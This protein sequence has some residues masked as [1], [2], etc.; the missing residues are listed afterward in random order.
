MKTLETI[1]FYAQTQIKEREKRIC[2]IDTRVFDNEHNSDFLKLF[3][4]HIFSF[5]GYL[6][7]GIPETRRVHYIY[8][9]VFIFVLVRH[10][11]AKLHSLQ[12]LNNVTK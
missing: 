10:H 7:K 1:K 3:D 8:I 12:P 6:M 9:Y 11:L 5:W 2:C 4:F